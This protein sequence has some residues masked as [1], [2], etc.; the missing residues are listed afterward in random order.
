MRI[1]VSRSM[2]MAIRSKVHG[3]PVN[4]SP[5]RPP[6]GPAPR[7]P[8]GHPT[9]AVPARSGPDCAAPPARRSA[10]GGARHSP[11]GP[12][13]RAGGRLRPGGRRQRI[14]RR[15]AAGEP[16]ASHVL[17]SLNPTPKSPTS[18]RLPSPDRGPDALPTT[19]AEWSDVGTLAGV[20]SLTRRAVSP[21]YGPDRDQPT[22]Y[23][24][25][26]AAPA[27]KLTTVTRLN[28]TGRTWP[29]GWWRSDPHR[30]G[31]PTALTAR[32]DAAVGGTPTRSTGLTPAP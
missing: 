32:P 1:A 10:S 4:P 2:T 15:R 12:R 27:A 16:G 18:L 30:P 23:D 17:V 8:A 25:G 19:G 21:K 28:V 3:S 20:G 26:A 6:A 31:P 11:P 7:W 29:V 14:A 24:R 13:R 9:A 22:T 5:S